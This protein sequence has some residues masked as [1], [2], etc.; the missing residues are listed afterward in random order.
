M[1]LMWQMVIDSIVVTTFPVP[2]NKTLLVKNIV[3]PTRAVPAMVTRLA[4][5]K[6]VCMGVMCAGSEQKFLESVYVSPLFCK[7]M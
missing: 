5:A 4:S 3:L 7:S 6:K 2:S 1:G